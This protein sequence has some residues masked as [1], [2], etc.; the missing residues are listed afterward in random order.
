MCRVKTFLGFV[1]LETFAIVTGWYS[2]IK[3]FILSLNLLVVIIA[4]ISSDSV[5]SELKIFVDNDVHK[6]YFR[7]LSDDTMDF[8]FAYPVLDYHNLH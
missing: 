1:S 3:A 7:T 2:L 6:K 8:M 5:Q 4:T